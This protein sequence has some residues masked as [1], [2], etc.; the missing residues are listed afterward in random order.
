VKRNLKRVWGEG[1]Q[2][3][4]NTPQK[5]GKR[6][7][8]I[9]GLALKKE[10]FLPSTLQGRRMGVYKRHESPET[11]RGTSGAE[12]HQRTKEKQ[13]NTSIPGIDSL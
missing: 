8:G 13:T 11:Q 12:N 2:E 3:K 7:T 1:G 5:H 9:S 10:N 6:K 4:K